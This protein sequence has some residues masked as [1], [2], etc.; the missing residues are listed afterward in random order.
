[1]GAPIRESRPLD[2]WASQGG[3][4][5]D[6]GIDADNDADKVGGKGVGG[7]IGEMGAYVKG[8]AWEE[9]ARSFFV[10]FVE[11][12]GESISVDSFR[13]KKM[14]GESNDEGYFGAFRNFRGEPSQGRRFQSM[15]NADFWRINLALAKEDSRDSRLPRV[16]LKRMMQVV[17]ACQAALLT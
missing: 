10:I 8:W 15:L 11:V 5:Q 1:M 17:L 2:L 16:D 7:G 9:D 14:A 4:D 6:S 12:E 3:C 13:F